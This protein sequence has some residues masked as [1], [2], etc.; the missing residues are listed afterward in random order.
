MLLMIEGLKLYDLLL[1]L[2][3]WWLVIDLTYPLL[4]SWVIWWFNFIT[5]GFLLIVCSWLNSFES[6]PILKKSSK[7]CVTVYLIHPSK[8]C[9]FWPLQWS[10]FHKVSV[11]ICLWGQEPS[12][13]VFSSHYL[14]VW[15]AFRS[16]DCSTTPWISQ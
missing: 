2:W 12:S 7:W 15:L 11:L 13:L 16:C 10:F 14:S 6:L 5:V 9:E 3:L 1:M 4:I 8:G